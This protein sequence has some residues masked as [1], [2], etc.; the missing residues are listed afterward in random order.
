MVCLTSQIK[1][2]VVSEKDVVLPLD[3]KLTLLGHTLLSL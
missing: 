1:L 2:N 3:L